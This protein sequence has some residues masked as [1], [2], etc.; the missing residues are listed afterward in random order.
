MPINSMPL[1]AVGRT[2]STPIVSVKLCMHCKPKFFGHA[3]P[4]WSSLQWG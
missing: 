4:L 3:D 1:T 2:T